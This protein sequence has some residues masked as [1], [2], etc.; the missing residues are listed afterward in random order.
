MKN[1]KKFDNFDYDE[2]DD[3]ID[4][5]E[6]TYDIRYYENEDNFN[7]RRY[8]EIDSYIDDKEE[9]VQIAV[10][11]YL[12]NPNSV[13]K[14]ISSDDEYIVVPWDMDDIKKDFPD[15]LTKIEGDIY[16]L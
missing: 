6:I 3:D 13:V 16:N 1:I 9:A 10:E 14:V 8:I 12:K 15:L 4:N 7:S 5:S 11:K 2:V